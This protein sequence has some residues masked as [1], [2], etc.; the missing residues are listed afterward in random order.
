M[1]FASATVSPA[2]A[3]TVSVCQ[4]TLLL[5]QDCAVACVVAAVRLHEG[6]T[7]VDLEVVAQRAAESGSGGVTPD[8]LEVT[9]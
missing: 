3:L 1:L 4:V 2:T 9:L 8:V 7:V 6:R 5:L